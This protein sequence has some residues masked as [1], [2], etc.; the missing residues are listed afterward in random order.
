[1]KKIGIVGLSILAVGLLILS[2]QINVVG[3]HTVQAAQQ[4]ALKERLNQKDLVFT[5]I[6]DLVN[7]KEI[8]SAIL[9]AQLNHGFFTPNMKTTPI[10]VPILTK[11]QLEVAYRVGLMLSK[12]MSKSQVQ[13]LC[14][15]SQM[16]VSP[17]EISALVDK[18][19][20][21]KGDLAQLSRLSCGCGSNNITWHFPLV[22]YLVLLPLFVFFFYIIGSV[23]ILLDILN[24]TYTQQWAFKLMEFWVI[25]VLATWFV[26]AEYL[27]CT[28]WNF[29]PI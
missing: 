2:S 12:I 15:H 11:R 16:P 27:G 19:T 6:C 4:N 1:M 29:F 7:N 25:S 17:K 26:S 10:N 14:R 28:W 8:Q 21:L 23:V 13:A 24:I 18:D 22:C 9:T 5:T 20:R 3:Y